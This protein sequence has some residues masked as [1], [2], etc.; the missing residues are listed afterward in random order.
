M[1]SKSISWPLVNRR[2]H[3]VGIVVLWGRLALNSWTVRESSGTCADSLMFRSAVLPKWRPIL[4][5]LHRAVRPMKE[6]SPHPS[7]CHS[8]PTDT[9]LRWH[10]CRNGCCFDYSRTGDGLVHMVCSVWMYHVE[11][12]RV[13]VRAVTQ[14]F[15]VNLESVRYP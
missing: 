14:S 7:T 1:T 3:T 12:E 10:C 13:C 11:G 8:R 4:F 6:T 9:Q 2:V 5:S 15:S